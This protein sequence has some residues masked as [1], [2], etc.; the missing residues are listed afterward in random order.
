MKD[1]PREIEARFNSVCKETGKAIK[2]GERC[3]YYP[4][5]KSVFSLDSKQASEFRAWWYDLAMSGEA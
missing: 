3:I 2:K 1:D 5:S 4:R